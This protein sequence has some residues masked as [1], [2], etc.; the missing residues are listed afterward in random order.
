M[1]GITILPDLVLGDIAPADSAMLIV[2]GG[3]TMEAGKNPE[4]IEAARAFLE[5]GV[6]VA[7]ICGATM[8]FARAGLLDERRH[9]SNA[10][11][12]LMAT[13]YRGAALYEDAPAVTDGNLI[14]ASGIAPV[15][16]ARHIFQR[17]DLY[18]PEVLNAWYELF[19]HGNFVPY[20]TLMQA[21][22][23]QC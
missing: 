6:P 5:A 19:K 4:V 17:L 18:T 10:R 13:Q 8:A 3:T 15:D 21:N 7:A 16:F 9:T 12:Y 1:G 14:T 20:V 11:E 23:G 22:A 2:P